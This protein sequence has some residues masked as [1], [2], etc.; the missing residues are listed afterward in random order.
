MQPT[1]IETMLRIGPY[2]FDFPVTQAALAGYSDGPMRLVARRMGCPYALH[3]VL[4]DKSIAMPMK[5]RRKLLKPLASADHPVGGQ[6]MGAEPEQCA[7]AA[8]ILAEEGYDII[9]VNFGCPVK[10]VLGR[11]RAGF[12]LSTPAV[13]IDILRAV[14][15]AVSRETP[16][17]VKLRRGMDH[18]AESER[19]FY[20]IFDAACELGYA[21][22]T[23]HGRTVK[24]RY[25]GPS[26]WGFLAR[27]KR[28]APQQTIIGSGD[29]FTA[30]HIRSMF[31]QTGVDGVSV[32][33][34]AIGNPWIFR[35]ARALLSGKSL[36]A[37]PTVPE[38]GTIIREHF[39]LSVETH[40]EQRAARML[41]KVGI[42]YA[43]L[44]PEPKNVRMAFVAAKSAA[45]WLAVLDKWYDPARTW[46]PGRR[47]TGPTEL[48]A[49][50][51]TS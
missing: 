34:G 49:P 10:K 6:V 27:L 35:D 12:L 37:P 29:L 38:M 18:T 21:A 26:D 25:K 39:R 36:P 4:L 40:G 45:E 51:A 23:V 44:H 47:R 22:A 13:A 14:R 41:R 16:I 24:Q 32:A 33:R 28:H 17:T 50:G 46:P 7:E 11:R 19:A 8:A 30:D 2:E 48:V 1:I 5:V 31:D 3:Q 15:N 42:R 9:D 43:D 20:R